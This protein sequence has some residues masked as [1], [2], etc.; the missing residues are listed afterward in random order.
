MARGQG[1]KVEGDRLF[2]QGHVQA[3][4]EPLPARGSGL[5]AD[6][7]G[8]ADERGGAFQLILV[9]GD[10]PELVQVVDGRERPV[11]ERSTL[12][13]QGAP[14]ETAGAGVVVLEPGQD[15]ELGERLGG[16]ESVLADSRPGE[17]HGAFE[18]GAPRS[19][20]SLALRKARATVQSRLTVALEGA[21][22][23]AA[24]SRSR[25]RKAPPRFCAARVRQWST[26]TRRMTWAA[27]RKK[28]R[29]SCQSVRR[30]SSR[31][32]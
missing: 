24:S 28:C 7:L 21:G 25:A 23:W 26:S 12:G 11:A 10:E 22:T 19:R 6:A 17:R 30:W 8:G 1:A 32:R 31:R 4:G 14:E 18:V 29:R 3:V 16:G 15:A 27:M 2:E 5:A 9:Q 13:G 20:L